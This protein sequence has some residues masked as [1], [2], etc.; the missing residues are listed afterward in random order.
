MKKLLAILLLFIFTPILISCKEDVYSF[1]KISLLPSFSILPEVTIVDKEKRLKDIDHLRVGMNEIVR[2]LDDTFNVISKNESLIN[3]INRNAG[4]APVKVTE[5][6]IMVIKTAIEV[7]EN[8]KIDNNSLYD[9]TIFPVWE[10]WKFDSQYNKIDAEIPSQEEIVQ[11]LPL[12]GYDKI[13]IDEEKQTVYLTEKGMKIDLGSI[14]K[15]YACDKIKEYLLSQGYKNA[16]INVGGNIMTMG[17]DYYDDRP[18][19]IRIATPFYSYDPFNPKSKNQYYVGTLY[20]EDIT[21]VSSGVYERYITNNG[22]SY[23][24]ILNPL[25]GYPVDSGLISISIITDNSMIAD[26]LST[27]V[28]CMGLEKGASYIEGLDNVEAVFITDQKEVYNTSGLDFTFNQELEELG[29][30]YK[31]VINGTSN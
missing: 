15:G 16:L 13:E 30:S 27:A 18:W 29:Y 5:E 7:S 12:V 20:Y 23:H 6:V 22:K 26:A 25:T 24:H 19:R 8:T 3:Q 10:L 28:F 14:V 11:A 2:D 1:Q 4:I 21:V 31:G 9:I 17:Y